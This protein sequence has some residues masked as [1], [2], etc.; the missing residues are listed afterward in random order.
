MNSLHQP[1]FAFIFRLSYLLLL[2]FHVT[3]ISEGLTISRM[4]SKSLLLP[5]LLVYLVLALG[6]TGTKQIKS[7][8]AI[9]ALFFSWCG[10]LLLMGEG[11]HFFL[12]GMVGFML[13]HV[14]NWRF[15]LLVQPLRMSVNT[16]MGM[17]AAMLAVG[18]FYYVV[19]DQLGSF[20]MPV[21]I[22]MLLIAVS[23]ILS[24]NLLNHLDNMKKT[25]P[26]F[27]VGI[28]LFI[29]SDAVLAYNKFF[30]LS[31]MLLEV[32]VMV[33]YGIAQLT[34]TEGYLNTCKNG[35]TELE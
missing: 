17:A 7:R 4:I 1:R 25:A 20:L 15:L 2:G 5:L 30:Q 29:L 32:L 11:T 23:W 31:N 34:I 8:W 16:I 19:K 21:V 6:K 12:L 9:A 27:I 24:F 26:L 28:G 3:C 22:Y 33:T 14:C 35:T 18:F 10:D 13:T